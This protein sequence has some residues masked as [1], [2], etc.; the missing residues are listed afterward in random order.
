MK[1]TSSPSSRTPLNATVNAYQSSPARSL[2]ARCRCLLPLRAEGLVLVV[3]RLV[4]A[5]RRI[6]LRSHCRPNASSSAPTTRRSVS[7]GIEPSAGPSAAT[8]M[9]PGRPGPRRRRSAS[10]ASRARRRRPARSSAPRPSPRRWRGRR[11]RRRGIVPVLTRMF[12]RGL[13]TTSPLGAR[14]RSSAESPSRSTCQLGAVVMRLV[15]HCGQALFGAAGLQA[16]L[17]L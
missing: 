4:A 17:T 7:I 8:R 9:P 11:R 2:A 1:T 16:A 6:A 13:G 3:Q 5:Q 12:Y 14:R 15:E 10:S